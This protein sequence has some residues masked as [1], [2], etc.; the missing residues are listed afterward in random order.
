[1]NTKR[2]GNYTENT[3]YYKKKE[4]KTY[5]FGQGKK[6]VF[7]FP[8]FPH[9]GLLF[10]LFYALCPNYNVKYVTMDM[11]GWIG[12]SDNV[13]GKNFSY[14]KMLEVVQTVIDYY[15]PTDGKFS[16]LGYSFGTSLAIQVPKLYKERVKNIV[17]VSPVIN[18]NLIHT[19][20]QANILE[21]LKKRNLFDA[22]KYYIN[23]KFGKYTKT[24]IDDGFP[25]EFINTYNKLVLNMDVR[26]VMNSLYKLFHSDFTDDLKHLE[27]HNTLV[28]NSL[29]ES[30]VFIEQADYIRSQINNESSS[31]LIGSHEN[32]LLYPD[33]RRLESVLDFLSK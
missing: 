3:L 27:N 9:S 21:F 12:D 30:H 10:M 31:Y 16:V 17:L 18:G 26:I 13:Y 25:E 2:L 23:F 8:P 1:M 22:S 32:F 15:S 4:I 29:N 20:S 7:L 19:Y 33:K 5:V 6:L 11:P 14:G 24:L 28:I